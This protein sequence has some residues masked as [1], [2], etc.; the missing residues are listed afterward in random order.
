MLWKGKIIS[1]GLLIGPHH[2]LDNRIIIIPT[3]HYLLPVT[4]CLLTNNYT[5]QISA[6]VLLKGPIE[7]EPGVNSPI[8]PAP[9]FQIHYLNFSELFL[10]GFYAVHISRI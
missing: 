4:L 2:K 8:P 3:A 6:P 7:P 9:V 1:I 10:G 5:P